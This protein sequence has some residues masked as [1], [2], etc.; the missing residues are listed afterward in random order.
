[1][2]SKCCSVVKQKQ[3]IPILGVKIKSIERKEEAKATLKGSL[4]NQ[5][6]V[7]R[8]F[9]PPRERVLLFFGTC[10]M[11]DEPQLRRQA[12]ELSVPPDVHCG[13]FTC[14]RI[15]VILVNK[16]L[17]FCQNAAT[18]FDQPF[19]HQATE[20]KPKVDWIQSPPSPCAHLGLE[21]KQHAVYFTS[22][23]SG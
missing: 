2:M 20:I 12:A 11:C 22:G 8:P 9:H 6:S 14:L 10:I 19:L 1:M 4:Q 7:T 16:S 13:V 23:W 5:S 17:F 18:E 15:L 21:R 3:N